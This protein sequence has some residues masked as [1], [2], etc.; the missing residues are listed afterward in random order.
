MHN[1]GVLC[2]FTNNETRL[3][4]LPASHEG[5]RA[6]GMEASHLLNRGRG[7]KGSNEYR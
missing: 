7:L 5:Q 2:V 4:V 6:D 1:M 3:C